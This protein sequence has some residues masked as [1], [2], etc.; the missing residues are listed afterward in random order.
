M[1]NNLELHC[2]RPSVKPRL[3]KKWNSNYCS[4]SQRISCTTS[5]TNLQLLVEFHGTWS[6]LS[7]GSISCIFIKHCIL[8]SRAWAGLMDSYCRLYFM[9]IV[10]ETAQSTCCAMFFDSL[11]NVNSLLP[12]CLRQILGRWCWQTRF[13][14][15]VPSVTTSLVLTKVLS[16]SANSLDY[17]WD[18]G[19][20]FRF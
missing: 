9:L 18:Y 4:G 20:P 1:V 13:L 15:Y 5:G 6:S 7:K 2:R 16:N 19:F 11:Y 3:D 12:G 10:V 14:N 17:Y 8:P